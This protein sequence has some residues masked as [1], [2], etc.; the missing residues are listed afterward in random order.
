MKILNN[1]G[2]VSGG[3]LF[4]RMDRI[5]QKAAIENCFCKKR[6]TMTQQ[7]SIDY[8]KQC[9]DRKDLY[10][11]IAEII[12]NKNKCLCTVFAKSTSTG[13]TYAVATFSFAYVDKNYCETKD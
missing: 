7:A 4:D 3:Y 5:A 13:L 10:F 1:Y 6:F 2:F 11:V 9:C 12:S 8:L